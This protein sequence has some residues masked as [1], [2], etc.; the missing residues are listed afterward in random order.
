MLAITIFAGAR[1]YAL[2]MSKRVKELEAVSSMIKF[3]AAEIRYLMSPIQD[4]I[5]NLAEKRELSPL[6]FLQVCSNRMES[7]EDFPSAWKNA[8]EEYKAAGSLKDDDLRL[9]YSLGEEI[10]TSDALGQEQVCQMYSELISLKLEEARGYEAKYKEFY[11][12]LGILGG[13]AVIII[14][15]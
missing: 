7:G 2:S 10:G 12:A 13:L 1:A 11:S 3:I 5:K 14:L 15:I 4:I 9:L 8:V 6:T